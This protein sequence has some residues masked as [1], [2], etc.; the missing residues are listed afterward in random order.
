VLASASYRGEWSPSAKFST[1]LK[2]LTTQLNK[3]G[4]AAAERFLI[5]TLVVRAFGKAGFTR[6]Y[7][8]L[9]K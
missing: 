8:F 5:K 1:W 3:R 4:T 2:P 9:E 7:L 6:Y